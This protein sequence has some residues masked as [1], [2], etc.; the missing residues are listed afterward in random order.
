[1]TAPRPFDPGLQP[2]R[3]ELAWRRT[4]L[5]IAIGSLLSLRVFPVALPADADAWG[6]VPSVIGLATACVLWFSARRRQV[7]VT[8]ALTKTAGAD[9]RGAVHRGAGLPGA[10]LLLGLSAFSAGFGLLA[11]A[12]VVISAAT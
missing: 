9:H 3:T 4:A 10:G 5:A 12:L 1:M 8:A 6:F 2:E 7:R 11:L